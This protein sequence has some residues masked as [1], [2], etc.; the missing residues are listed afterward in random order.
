MFFCGGGDIIDEAKETK[1]QQSINLGGSEW[2]GEDEKG[3]NDT[4]LIKMIFCFSRASPGSVEK[5]PKHAMIQIIKLLQIKVFASG[6]SFVNQISGFVS[7]HIK[8]FW[9]RKNLIIPAERNFLRRNEREKRREKNRLIITDWCSRSKSGGQ[10]R[11]LILMSIHLA[12]CSKLSR[13][14]NSRLPGRLGDFDVI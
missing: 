6:F 3:R 4:K 13:P 12:E 11:S 1:R 8:Y 10:K 14:G 9:Y 7:R 2:A 5:A